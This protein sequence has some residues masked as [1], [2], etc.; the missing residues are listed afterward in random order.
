MVLAKRV[1]I[2]ISEQA[3][4]L[5]RSVEGGGAVETKGLRGDRRLVR[6]S[7]AGESGNDS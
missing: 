5:P 4:V 2:C 7:F 1:G 6:N 3:K